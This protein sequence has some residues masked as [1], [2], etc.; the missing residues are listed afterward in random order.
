M[1]RLASLPDGRLALFTFL[2]RQDPAD[3]IGQWQRAKN[4]ACDAIV[5]TSS[6]ITHHHAIGRDHARWLA[7][8]DGETGI[9]ALRAVK[10][11]LDPGG[12][13]N[14]GKLFV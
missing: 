11:E 7:A 10:A 4:A 9:A 13:M 8:E 1:P 2:A 6:T 14:P 3:P 12:I 5:A